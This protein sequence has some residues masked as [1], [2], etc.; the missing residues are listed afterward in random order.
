MRLKDNLK[1]KKR[2]NKLQFGG[3]NGRYMKYI[4]CPLTYQKGTGHRYNMFLKIQQIGCR[5]WA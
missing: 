4:K 3:R 1:A 2:L 5:K